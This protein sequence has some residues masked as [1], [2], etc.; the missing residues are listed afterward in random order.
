MRDDSAGIRDFER[1]RSAP[2]STWGERGEHGKQAEWDGRATGRRSGDGAGGVGC[3]R[4]RGRGE[5]RDREKLGGRTMPLVVVLAAALALFAA[6]A[7]DL[8]R[9]GRM[10]GA[11]D[12]DNSSWVAASMPRWA[13]WLALPFTWLGG[14]IGVTAVVVLACVWLLRRGGRGAGV[15]LLVVTLGISS[16]S[17]T[18]KNGYERTRPDAG[19][20]IELPQSFSFPSGHA[21][22]IGVFGLLGVLLLPCTGTFRAAPVARDRGLRARPRDRREPRRPERSLRLRRARGRIPRA[23]VARRVRARLRRR[24]TMTANDEPLPDD[25]AV[26]YLDR[27][28]LDRLPARRHRCTRASHAAAAHLEL[29]AVRDAGHRPRQTAR[30]RPARL[31]PPDPRRP[32]G[33][34]LPPER[35]ILGSSSR[36]WASM[37]HDTSPECT[38]VACRSRPARTVTTSALT[39]RMPDG[40]I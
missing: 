10:T 21:A 28:G 1:G 24:A 8:V 20:P 22:G 6:L 33:L 29:G 39:V 30:H 16:S 17:A 5:D 18:G 32:R 12:G 37:S 31:C 9:G 34:L 13:E 11:F 4:P 25:V 23:R 3:R 36:G 27:L 38:V 15:L 19:S 2:A 40:G 7:S 26:A 14:A 35:R